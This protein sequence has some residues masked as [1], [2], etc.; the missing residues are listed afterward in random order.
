MA[1]ENQEGLLPCP[2]CGKPSLQFLEHSGIDN[3]V[4]CM[5]GYHGETCPGTQIICSPQDWN[6]R[7]PSGDAEVSGS[8]PDS[9]QVLR[10]K[11][12][13]TVLF[14]TGDEHLNVFD[15]AKLAE[16]AKAIGEVDVLTAS[17]GY[18]IIKEPS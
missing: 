16:C 1:P 11:R 6:T 13:M 2:F 17:L 18:H 10:A 12:L 14:P 7:I 8:V 5:G 3:A 15:S 4:M 9:F